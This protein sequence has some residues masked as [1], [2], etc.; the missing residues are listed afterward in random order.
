MVVPAID[1]INGVRVR[2]ASKG[3]GPRHYGPRRVPLHNEARPVAHPR[4]RLTVAI[5][6]C[7]FSVV[8]M[9]TSAPSTFAASTPAQPLYAGTVHLDQTGDACVAN[10]WRLVADKSEGRP[11]DPA[12]VCPG[13]GRPYV[14]TQYRGVTTISCPDPSRHGA[15]SISARTDTKIPVVR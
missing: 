12:I 2:T 6:L 8:A 1:S 13:D 3:S 5:A 4:R 11:S 7:L 9:T 14:Y 10:I 15:V